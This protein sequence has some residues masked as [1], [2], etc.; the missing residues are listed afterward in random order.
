MRHSSIRLSPRHEWAVYGVSALV[1]GTGAIWAAVHFFLSAPNEFGAASPAESFLLKAHGAA[2]MA[3][4]VLLGT[5]LPTHMKFAWRAGRNLRSGLTLITVFG[6]IVLTG[7]GLYYVGGEQLRAWTSTAH[8]WVGLLL[9]V[10][11]GV[12]VW[13]GKRSR[14]GR[15]SAPQK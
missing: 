6:F 12:H 4:L 5:L 13:R 9:P 1:F 11:L 2:A 10:V 14:L 7:Y 8:L 15:A 3:T